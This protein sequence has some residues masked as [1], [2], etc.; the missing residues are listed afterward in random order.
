M[1]LKRIGSLVLAFSQEDMDQVRRLYDNGVKNG[2]PG[3]EIL[4]RAQAM[5]KQ[6]ASRRRSWARSGR[7]RAPSPVRTK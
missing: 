6:P 7:R 5:E 2:V 4:D 1:P 3:L